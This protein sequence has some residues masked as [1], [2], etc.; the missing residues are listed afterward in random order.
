MITTEEYKTLIEDKINREDYINE[1]NRINQE[2]NKRY[3]IFENLFLENLIENEE[4]HLENMKNV[5]VTD[6]HYEQ[7]FIK[8]L[9][10]GID[11]MQYINSKIHELKH[12]FD[13]QSSKESEE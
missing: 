4:Y 9:E 2:E 12:R 6:Y 10:I 13:N 3:K 11:D 5:N 7:L 1:I 8:F